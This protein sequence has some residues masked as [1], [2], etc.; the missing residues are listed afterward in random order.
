MVLRLDE[1]YNMIHVAAKDVLFH[2][3]CVM[4]I[5]WVKWVYFCLDG[6]MRVFLVLWGGG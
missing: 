5:G 1:E 6:K 4:G 3:M 2:P